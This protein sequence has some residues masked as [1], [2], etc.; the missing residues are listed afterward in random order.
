MTGRIL[1]A[2][3]SQDVRRTLRAP[4]ESEGFAVHEATDASDAF[5]HLCSQRFD[6]AMIDIGLPGDGLALVEQVASNPD[7]AGTAMVLLTEDLG[8][9][10]VLDGLERG[11]TD[12][13]RKPI[14]PIEAVVRATAALRISS[15]QTRVVEGNE[16][17]T[18]LAAT[19]DLTG[20][21]TRRF[22]ESHLRG[23]VA[24]AARHGRPLTV[25]MLDLDNFKEINDTHGHPT[26][27]IVLQAAVERIRERLRQEDLLGR[28]GGDELLLVLPDTDNEGALTLGE[29]LRRA[30]TETEIAVDGERIPVT[31]SVGVATWAD[32]EPDRLIQRA[33][34]ALYQ[35]KMLG[36]DRVHT[37]EPEHHHA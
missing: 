3:S 29:E 9:G 21:L 24:A 5:G 13:L 12:C 25:A 33:D 35:A 37:S 15:L 36:R 27:D 6:V 31:L 10:S 22:L 19:D 16:R 32:E 28:W 7:L 30:I 2:D 1:I 14:E 8:E 34:A 18:E 17:L 20:V 11:A 23:L 4:L 26:G